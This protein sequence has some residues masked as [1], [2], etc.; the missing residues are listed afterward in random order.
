MSASASFRID[1]RLAGL[2]YLGLAISGGLGFLMVRAQLFA[3][4]DPART[5]ANLLA[6]EPLARMGRLTRR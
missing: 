6:H 1:C 2:F 3:D 5:V 4:A